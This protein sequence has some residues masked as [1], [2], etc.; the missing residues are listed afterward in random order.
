M[1]LEAARA[2]WLCP[3]DFRLPWARSPMRG[4]EGFAL[5]AETPEGRVP[6][7]RVLG[8]NDGRSLTITEGNNEKKSKILYLLSSQVLADELEEMVSLVVRKYA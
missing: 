8:S 7:P 1:S 6:N 3:V 5:L 4:K 2:A